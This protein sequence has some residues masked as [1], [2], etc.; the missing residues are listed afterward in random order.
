[1]PAVVLESAFG[2]QYEDT[3]ASYQFPERYL[4]F[5]APLSQGTPVHAVIYEPRGDDGRGKMA[6]VGLATISRPPVATGGRSRNGERLLR[7]DY[8]G[9]A[10]A[11]DQEVRREVMGIPVEGWLRD[12]PHGRSRNVATF[13]RAVR[14]LADED[15]ERI[16][17]LG[18]APVL[19]TT[20]YP[21]PA[22]HPEQLEQV[23]DRSERLVAVIQRDA[24]FRQ[25]VLACYDNRCSVSGFALG[26][27]SPLKSTGLLEAAHIRPV[28]QSGPDG[29]RNGISL[30]PTLH[31]LF[32]AGLFTVAYEDGRPVVRTSPR[33]QPTMISV[34]AR[35]FELPLRD[36]LQ[37]LTPTNNGD[38]P[39]PDQVLYH[40]R[41]IFRSV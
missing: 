27:V 10:I 8:D 4:K 13:G 41:E 16:L 29:V 31:R 35:G 28:G 12:V 37:L 30:T 6:Y 18:N 11:F 2:S 9:P 39:S 1:M 3:P 19:E 22:E 26:P 38:W 34:P 5:F 23:R 33:L 14:P 15:F 24:R 20:T 40:Q 32:D 21:V 7:V 25:V 17:Q 36:G